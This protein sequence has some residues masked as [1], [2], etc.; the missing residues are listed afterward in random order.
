MF[1]DSVGKCHRMLGL[2]PGLVLSVVAVASCGSG[3]TAGSAPDSQAAAERARI[4]ALLPDASPAQREALADGIVTAGEADRAASDV[5]DCAAGQGIVVT[6]IWQ[7]GE[8]LF[9]TSG[10]RTEGS[11]DA[12]LTIFDKCYETYFSLVASNLSL[13]NSI[14]PDLVERRNQLVTDCLAAAGFDVGSWPDVR[15][16]PDPAVESACIDAARGELGL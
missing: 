14:A 16:E 5:V 2:L 1:S 10:G 11:A 8:M 12:A 3:G 13:Q 7:D 4:E 15:V 9:N 6:P